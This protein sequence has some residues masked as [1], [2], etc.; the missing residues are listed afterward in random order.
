MKLLSRY[1]VRKVRLQT[2][3]VLILCTLVLLQAA[4]LGGFS[5]K[6]L[7]NSMEEQIGM[8]ALQMSNAVALMPTVREGILNKDSVRL[9]ELIEEIRATGDARFIVIGNRNGVRLTHPIEE[10]IGHAM[11]GG[12]NHRA[13][14]LGESYI[15]KAVGSLG[16]SIRGKSPVRDLNGN[17]IGVV[18]V[19]YLVD[20]VTAV[21]DN[22]Q[23]K[24]VAVIIL[25]LLCSMFAAAWA[26]FRFKQ[27]IFGLEP[28]EIAQL[29]E[30]RH[31]TLES[32]REG[33]IAIN[34]EGIITTFNRTAHDTLGLPPQTTVIGRHIHDVLPHSNLVNVLEQAEPQFD[35]EVLLN[36]RTLIVNRIPIL[37][38]DEITGVVSS[39]RRKDEIDSI[40]RRLTRIQ[41]YADTLRSQAHEYSNKL[42]TISGL[43]QI[44]NNDQALELIGQE[45][46]G[47]QALIRLLVDAVPD[48]LLSGCL[49]GKYNRAHELGLELEIDSESSM[50]DIPAHINPDQLVTVIGN[51]LDNAYDATMLNQGEK[52]MLSMTDYGQDIIF[53]I[54]DQGTGISDEMMTHIFEKG[55]SSKAA[56]G[57]GI[58]MFLV[59]NIVDRLKGEITLDNTN[60]GGARITL[61]LPKK[62]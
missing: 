54:E 10:R 53:E 8:R 14:E 34:D 11:K 13:L 48:P 18:S 23:K 41:Q 62:V 17:I 52:V 6:H 46:R 32:I 9:Q 15:S 1:K 40:S 31:A 29:F 19:G 24:I 3:M 43:I 38:D 50:R 45:T 16:P 58:G 27:A 37:V 4:L 59:K 61:Y 36:E 55:V 39:F 44:G 2:R 28:E 25:A 57:R 5:L 21:I 35:Q 47:H 60:S 26:A 12:D 51:L 33:I 49:L 22:Y 7:A 20:S 56:E 42:H 30:E